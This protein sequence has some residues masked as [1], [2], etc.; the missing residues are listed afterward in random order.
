LIVR[1]GHRYALPSNISTNTPV[2]REPEAKP[3]KEAAAA[4]VEMRKPRAAK[5]APEP[6]AAP[7]PTP[8]P[9]PTPEPAAKS[10]A[11]VH[12]RKPEFVLFVGELQ[13]L[14]WFRGG[15][16][17]QAEESSIE[18]TPEQTRALLVLAELRK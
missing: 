10:V 3:P 11:P 9:A 4:I 7:S 15:I 2:P 12:G 16:T 6:E 14:A 18:L 17:I 13:L 8:A 5:P 1:D